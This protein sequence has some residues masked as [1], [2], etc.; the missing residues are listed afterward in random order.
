MPATV[1]VDIG[2][3]PGRSA[4]VWLAAAQETIATVRSRPELG[5]PLDVL[6]GFDLYLGLWSGA[7]QEEVFRWTG[8][9]DPGLLRHLAANWARLANLAREADGGSGI[10]PADAEGEA[11]FSALAT[12]MA[13]ALARAD[14]AERF[15]AKFEEVIPDFVEVHAPVAITTTRVLL[16]DDNPDIRLL[17]RIGLETSGGLEVVGEACDGAEAL[18][19]VEATCPDAVLLDLAMPVMDGFQALPLLRAACPSA[20]IVVF[21]AN[22]STDARRRVHEGGATAF[23]R[24]DAAIADVVAALRPEADG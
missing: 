17:L 8:E 7:M 10:R 5:V 21:S 11:F 4:R 18:Q 24:K 9:V 14:D 13:D 1:R 16:V 2:P 23:L 20:R 12:G 15:A 19:A 3:A 22:D 6:A